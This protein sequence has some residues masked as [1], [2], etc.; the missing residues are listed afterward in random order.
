MERIKRSSRKHAMEQL[1]GFVDSVEFKDH[2]SG[3]K[4][5]HV[6]D[7]TLICKNDTMITLYNKSE[8]EKIEDIVI[9]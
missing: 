2:R 5:A 9:E 6:A 3:A 7:L 1:K 4:Y 8:Y